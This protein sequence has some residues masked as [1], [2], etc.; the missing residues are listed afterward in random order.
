MFTRTYVT[1]NIGSTSVRLLSVE[2][3]QVKKWGSMPLPPGL[4]KDGLILR[5]KVVGALISTLFKSVGVPKKQVIASLAGLSFIHRI[6]SLPRMEHGS[7]SEAIHRAARKEMMLPPEELY[8]SW[9]NIDD[10]DDEKSFFVLGVPCHPIDVLVE[11]LAEAS[12]PPYLVDL[13][14][15]ALARTVHRNE[16]I[17]VNLEPDCFDIVLISDGMPAVMHTITPRGEGATLEDNIRRLSD[18]LLKTIEFFNN[19][20]PRNPINTAMPV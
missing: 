12:I 16:A 9:Q 17:V 15:L 20:H 4:V 3:R 10:R 7:L 8:L 19:N 18:E 14:P 13:N 11:T 5:P 2:G 6:L 1:L